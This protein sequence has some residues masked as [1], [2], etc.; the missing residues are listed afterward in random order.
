V[1]KVE[2][3]CEV[4]E[5]AFGFFAAGWE[6]FA[7]LFVGLLLFGFG[8]AIDVWHGIGL[9]F[10]GAALSRAAAHGFRFG[11]VELGR[12]RMRSISRRGFSAGAFNP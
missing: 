11:A 9:G 4:L 6:L 3:G 1:D 10:L 8:G 12:A 7:Y 2:L 5:K